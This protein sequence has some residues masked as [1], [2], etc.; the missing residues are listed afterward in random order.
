METLANLPAIILKGANGL[1]ALAFLPVQ[2]QS[3]LGRASGSYRPGGG[4]DGA[5]SKEI[6]FDIGGGSGQ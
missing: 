2:H 5:D 4:A 3:C 6:V 1:A